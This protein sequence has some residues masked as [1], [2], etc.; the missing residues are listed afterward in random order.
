[1][2]HSKHDEDSA[3]AMALKLRL[4]L[5]ARPIEICFA[6]ELPRVRLSTKKVLTPDAIFR[7]ARPGTSE[8]KM[9]T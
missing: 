2:T 4:N 5:E 1:M 9:F 3:N 7:T 6:T 8:L